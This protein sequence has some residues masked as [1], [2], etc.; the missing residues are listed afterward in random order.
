M[1]GNVVHTL[2]GHTKGV[3]YL[4]FHPKDATL[5]SASHDGS[6]RLWEKK[7]LELL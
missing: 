1:Q 7:A 2:R 4:S 3:C 5:L 6:V